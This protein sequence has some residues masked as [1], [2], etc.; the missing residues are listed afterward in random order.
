MTMKKESQNGFT[1][2]ELVVSVA[3]IGII[4]LGI[5]TLGRN[6]FYFKGIFQ[7]GISAE[8]EVRRVLRP[9]AD[10]LRSMSVSSQ[11]G[12]PIESATATSVVFFSDISSNSNKERIRYYLS[13]T[14]LIKGVIVATGNPLTYPSANEVLTTMATSVTNG[15]TP[16]FSYYDATYTGTENPLTLPVNVSSIR[17]IKITLLVEKDPNRSPTIATLTTQVML[18]NLKDNL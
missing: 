4:T 5:G 7:S 18:R 9:M 16:I 6:I 10:E 12:Y 3:V 8:D 14:T 2:M 17:L 13:G 11:G 15:A 1:L